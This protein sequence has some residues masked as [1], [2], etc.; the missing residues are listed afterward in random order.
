MKNEEYIGR[1]ATIPFGSKGV[2]FRVEIIGIK[3]AY[4]RDLYEI[5]PVAGSGKMWVETITLLK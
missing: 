4:G 5:T 3:S 2:K 1:E